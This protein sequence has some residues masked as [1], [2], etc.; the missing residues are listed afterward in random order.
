LPP[1]SDEAADQNR[2]R[3]DAG[4]TYRYLHDR[5]WGPRA[6]AKSN[7]GNLAAARTQFA[8]QPAILAQIEGLSTMDEITLRRRYGERLSALTGPH[9]IHIHTLVDSIVLCDKAPRAADLPGCGGGSPPWS[10]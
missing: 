10:R 3:L 5:L 7:M 4:L 8:D 9:N 2:A 6:G 1:G